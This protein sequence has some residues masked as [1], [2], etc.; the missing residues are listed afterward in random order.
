MKILNLLITIAVALVTTCVVFFALFFWVP[1][2]IFDK[3]TT[4]TEEFGSTITTILGTDTISSSRSVI[5]TNF[6]NLNTD[7]LES[8]STAAA[9]TIGT[10]TLS[11]ALTVANGG[12]GSTTLSANQILLG[13]GTGGVKTPAGWGTSGFFLQSTGFGSAPVWAGASV[14]L[15]AN[16][17]WTGF[18]DFNAGVRLMGTSSIQASVAEKLTINGLDY[19]FPLSHRSTSSP[20]VSDGSGALS[21]GVWSVLFASGSSGSTALTATTTLQTLF[22]PANTLRTTNSMLRLTV[23][24]F[25]AAPTGS[26]YFQVSYGTG[27]ATSSMGYITAG[28]SGS[29]EGATLISTISATST[30]NQ[31]ANTQGFS[32]ASPA[33][34]PVSTGLFWRSY[35]NVDTTGRTY[36]DIG[37]KTSNSASCDLENYLLEVLSP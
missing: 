25:N 29:R 22:I 26:C 19:S 5:N 20:L 8:G 1:I 12:T 23:N 17:N 10:L 18:H 36:I 34:A 16:Y 11:N 14:D 4:Q 24:G 13:N 30:S 33:D 15:A 6:A 7:K 37:A 31:F 3:L 32:S 2:G 28:G 9:L 21:W 27:F 35:H